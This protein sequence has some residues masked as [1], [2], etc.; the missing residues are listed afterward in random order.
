MNELVTPLYF[1][2]SEDEYG[3]EQQ[4]A[5][6]TIGPDKQPHSKNT[7]SITNHKV[8]ADNDIGMEDDISMVCEV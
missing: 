3:G 2:F 8:D 6:L 4:P 7:F 5:D 1:N